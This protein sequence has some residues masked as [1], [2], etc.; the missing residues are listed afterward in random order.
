[1]SARDL[2]PAE[3]DFDFS[4]ERMVLQER[5]ELSTSL[6]LSLTKGTAFSKKP[7]NF[8]VLLLLPFACL[9]ICRK[10]WCDNFAGLHRFFVPH[11]TRGH[12]HLIGHDVFTVSVDFD[13]LRCFPSAGFLDPRAESVGE[14]QNLSP[15]LFGRA[16]D[17]WACFAGLERVRA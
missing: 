9:G 4:K 16:K 5:I 17:N 11:F 8:I 13:G 6:D 14:L 1:V 2:Y 15:P 7:C 12:G 3:L 10:I